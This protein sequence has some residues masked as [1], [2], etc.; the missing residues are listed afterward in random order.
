MFGWLRNREKKVPAEQTEAFKLGRKAAASAAADLDRFM[1]RRFEPVHSGYLKVLRDRIERSFNPPEAPPIIMARIEYKC[2]LE[3]VDELR[4]KMPP[5]ILAALREW[6]N[7]ADQIGN[8][9]QFNELINNRVENYMSKLK[10]DGVQMLLDLVV[11]LKAADDR[12][13]AA[14]PEKSAQFPPDQ[15]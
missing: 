5:E 1:R 4:Q 15:S 13:R 11:S 10:T 9:E 8:R 3:S 12:W 2:F 14:N 7:V 6:A